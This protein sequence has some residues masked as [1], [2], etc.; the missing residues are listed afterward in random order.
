MKRSVELFTRDTK[1]TAGL[2]KRSDRHIETGMK[3]QKKLMAQKLND[4]M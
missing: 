3:R 1:D 4:C 2:D